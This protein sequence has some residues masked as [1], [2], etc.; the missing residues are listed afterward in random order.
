MA[1][2]VTILKSGYEA[3]AKGHVVRALMVTKR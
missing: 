2:N 1:D 3:L